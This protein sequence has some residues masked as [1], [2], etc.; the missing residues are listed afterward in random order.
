MN[1]TVEFQLSNT[2]LKI[3]LEISIEKKKKKSLAYNNSQDN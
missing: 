2:K 1:Q 3:N